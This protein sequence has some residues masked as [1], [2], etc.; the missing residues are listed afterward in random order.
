MG[1]KES[2]DIRYEVSPEELLAN[3]AKFENGARLN[4][5][6]VNRFQ[7]WDRMEKPSRPWDNQA[8]QF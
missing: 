3:S 8:K 7:K 1:A 4:R 2:I 5:E 6:P